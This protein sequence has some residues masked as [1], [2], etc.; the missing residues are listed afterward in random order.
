MHKLFGVILVC[1]VAALAA[2]TPI[3][4]KT[5][6]HVR[7]DSVGQT[8]AE[9]NTQLGIQY[10]SK[11][12]KES[13]LSKLNKALKQDPDYLLAHT[14]IALLYE[15]LGEQKLAEEHYRRAYRIDDTDPVN[16]NN[17]GQFLCRNGELEKAEKMFR[18][19]LKDPLYRYPDMVYTNAGICARQEPDIEKAEEFFRKALE[20]NPTYA[21]ALSQMIRIS[22]EKQNYLA[23]RA[24][25]QRAQQ[26][27]KLSPE[28]LWIGVQSEAQLGNKDAAASYALSL[29]NLYP[30]STQTE[31]LLKWE[32]QKGDR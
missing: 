27:A 30:T 22:F 13:A 10:M 29:K 1:C 16:L 18:K 15:Q 28:F 26:Q 4:T 21:P 19:A 9:V 6:T 3:Q 14:S 8:P 11:G 17:Y 20:K 24:Y 2:C 25:L 5:G 32:Q 31:A 12:M 23:T 7:E